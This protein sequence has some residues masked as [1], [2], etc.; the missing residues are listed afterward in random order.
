[1]ADSK[2]FYLVRHAKPTNVVEANPPLSLRG[3]EQAKQVA[4]CLSEKTDNKIDRILTSPILGAKETAQTIADEFEDLEVTEDR[5]LID[6]TEKTISL[7]D[8]LRDS[9]AENV[10]LVTHSHVI[11]HLVKH[12]DSTFPLHG[13]SKLDVISVTISNEETRVEDIWE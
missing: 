10:V 4:E 1:M 5:S 2:V 11:D 6:P 12:F 13:R 8:D 9:D 3:R 7:L